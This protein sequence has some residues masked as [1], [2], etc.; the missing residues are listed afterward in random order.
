MKIEVRNLYKSFGPLPVLKGV[1]LEVNRGE[2]VALLGPSGCGKTTLLRIIAG[3]EYADEGRVLF[4]AEDVVDR[5]VGQR[6]LGFVFQHFA[7]FRH[8]TVF[9]NVAFGLRVRSRRTRPSSAEIRRRVLELLRLVRLEPQVNHLPGELSGGQRQRVALARALAVEPQVLLL[10]EPFGSLDAQVRRELRVWLRRLHEQ[11]NLTSLFVTHDQEEALELADRV[12]VLHAG[13]VVQ[14]G[15]PEEVYRRPA[16][17]FV[18]DFLGNVNVFHGRVEGRAVRLGQAALAMPEGTDYREGA[19]VAVYVRPH[20]LEIA[21]LLTGTEPDREGRSIFR[22][23]IRH[24]NVAGP[25]VRIELHTEW[26][27]PALIEMPHERHLEMI[28]RGEGVNL[29]RGQEVFVRVL[30]EHLFIMESGSSPGDHGPR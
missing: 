27:A 11:L 3:L 23:Q 20:L 13:Q 14:V 7:L 1:S 6:R 29:T 21:G 8:M 17:A 5:T 18:Y 16:N 9:E 4:D 10:D 15:T 25:M 28:R 22:A 12:A 24:I 19:Q 26:D 30:P 2:L